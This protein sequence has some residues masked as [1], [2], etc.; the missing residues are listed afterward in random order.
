GGVN[1]SV[2]GGRTWTPQNNQPTAQIYRVST[3][4]YFPYRILGAQ[5]DNSALRILSRSPTGKGI[6]LNDWEIT[7][8]GESG[9]VVADPDNPEI[10]YGGSYGGFVNR[11]DHQTQE[12]RDVNPW[13]NDP[14]G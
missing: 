3:D 5:Q 1:V 9:H 12:F 11:I 2:D 14:M 10:V 13:P 8:G 6:G 4:N 7:A